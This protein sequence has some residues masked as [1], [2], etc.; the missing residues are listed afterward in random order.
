MTYAEDQ[1]FRATHINPQGDIVVNWVA[2]NQAKAD[3][4]AFKKWC[5]D[6]DNGIGLTIPREEKRVSLRKIISG[7]LP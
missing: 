1:L 7:I 6:T 3:Q 5:Q 4:D 2:L